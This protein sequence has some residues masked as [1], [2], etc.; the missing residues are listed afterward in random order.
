MYPYD[1]GSTTL[2]AI[3]PPWAQEGGPEKVL[4]KL[5]DKDAIEKMAEQIFLR[6]DDDWENFIQFSKGGLEGIVISDAPTTHQEFIGKSL[7]EIGREAGF[8]PSNLAGKRATFSL[9]CKLL[10]ETKLQL[11]ML[12]QLR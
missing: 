9:I 7:A 5:Q 8:N 4:Q 3:L 6:G 10:F 11:A 1:A 12:I 2:L